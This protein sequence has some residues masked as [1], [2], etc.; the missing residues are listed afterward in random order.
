M[1]ALGCNSYGFLYAP[2]ALP[3]KGADEAPHG[4]GPP[5][6]ERFT[7][8]GR[9]ACG[10]KGSLSPIHQQWPAIQSLFEHLVVIVDV[11]VGET[12]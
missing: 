4:Q 3:R 7:D 10:G 12:N 9:F 8:R 5:G 6:I 1:T 11:G 2:R